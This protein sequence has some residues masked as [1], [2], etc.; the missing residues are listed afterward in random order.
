MKLIY[1]L[2]PDHYYF[3]KKYFYNWQY[4][5]NGLYKIWDIVYSYMNISTLIHFSIGMTETSFNNMRI[6]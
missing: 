2:L 3:R 5:E 4:D 1:I 6:K